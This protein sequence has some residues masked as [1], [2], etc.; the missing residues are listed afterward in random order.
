MTFNDHWTGKVLRWRLTV[1]AIVI[2]VFCTLLS[3]NN[4]AADQIAQI[5]YQLLGVQVTIATSNLTVPRNTPVE[6]E[7]NVIDGGLSM[8]SYIIKANLRGPSFVTPIDIQATPGQNILLPGLRQPGIHFLENIR[9]EDGHGTIIPASPSS[10]TINVLDE[11]LVGE[12]TSRQLSLDEIKQLGIEFDE[13]S[14]K[15]FEFAIALTTSSGVLDLNIPALVPVSN[16]E[17]TSNRIEIPDLYGQDIP[18]LSLSGFEFE[19]FML[20]PIVEDLPG[21]ETEI[22]PIPGII[23]IPGNVAFLNHFFSVFLAVSNEAPG[24]DPAGGHQC[25]RGDQTPDGG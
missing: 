18:N 21:S 14:F 15:A 3:S 24:R 7:A 4:V 19:P 1:A 11:L 20:E 2:S 25:A 9:L 16:P 8:E 5:E 23:V 13:N 22:P 17:M 10:V 6:V 12:V